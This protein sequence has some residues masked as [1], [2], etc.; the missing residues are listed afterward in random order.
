MAENNGKKNEIVNLTPKGAAAPGTT[1]N[2]TAGNPAGGTGNEEEITFG[3]HPIKWIK[4]KAKAFN[5]AHPKAKY[6]IAAGAAGV[7]ALGVAVAKGVFGGGNE[8][9]PQI[10]PDYEPEEEE[11]DED[12]SDDTN[13]TEE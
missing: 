8:E 10:D 13:V 5:E 11:M 9:E 6:F 4:A 3:K 12:E 7:T 2:G 1:D